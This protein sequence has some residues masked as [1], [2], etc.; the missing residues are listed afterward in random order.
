MA[1]RAGRRNDIANNSAQPPFQP[2]ANDRTAD[3]LRNGE[4]D[5]N[6]RVGIGAIAREQD[7]PVGHRAATLVGGKEIAPRTK[8]AEFYASQR[9]LG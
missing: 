6:R 8:T 5:A 9:Q 2:V 7:E 3:F 4:A 1:R